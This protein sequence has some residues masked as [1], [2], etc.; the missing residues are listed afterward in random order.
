MF[1]ELDI[2]I[3]FS[4]LR[5]EDWLEES[6]DRRGLL[7]NQ[8]ECLCTL[9]GPRDEDWSKETAVCRKLANQPVCLRAS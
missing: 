6:A 2:S 5:D 7:T 1:E 8:P 3:A 9:S 4:G